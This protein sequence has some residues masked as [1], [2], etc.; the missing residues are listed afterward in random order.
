MKAFRYQDEIKVFCKGTGMSAKQFRLKL[1]ES[2]YLSL[3]LKLFLFRIA[4]YR[5]VT[6]EM[7]KELCAE[8]KI[9]V[10]DAKRMLQVWNQH[11]LFRKRMK[12]EAKAVHKSQTYL[13]TESG[14]NLFFNEI[15]P[16]VYKKIKFLA[17]KKLRFIAK[18]SNVE[19]R[20]LENELLSKVVQAY[21]MMVPI[22]KTELHVIN[23]LKRV[24]HNHAM[25]IIKAETSLKKG[26][27]VSVGTDKEQNRVFSLLM[28]SENQMALPV[29]GSDASYDEVHGDTS[30][31]LEKFEL[32]FSVSE[33]LS[34]LQQTSKKYRF[35]KLLMGHEDSEFTTW[36]QAR[37][38][39]TRSEDNVDVQLKLT[40]TEFNKLLSQF[41]NVAEDKV[42]AFIL[43]LRRDLALPSIK[44]G[45][46][47]LHI[48]RVPSSIDK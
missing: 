18:S 3:S 32:E 34:R 8:L 5:S 36:L 23:Y 2:R 42:N 17:Y 41:L 9:K 27:L 30:N 29:D 15:Y 35:L 19:L 24:A 38:I 39:A 16:D 48:K 44:A 7:V 14:L 1:H 10:I 31:N 33:I 21:Y 25:N 12:A 4:R 46:S 6:L 43:K 20:D 22:T 13:L 11:P 40:T 45:K 26:R 47:R 37:K 28:V